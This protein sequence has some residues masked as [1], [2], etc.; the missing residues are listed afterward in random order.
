MKHEPKDSKH[1][2]W[3]EGLF[4]FNQEILNQFPDMEELRDNLVPESKW[5]Y[6]GESQI[7]GS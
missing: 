7:R 2:E 6:M 4:E 5:S 1:Q 3:P